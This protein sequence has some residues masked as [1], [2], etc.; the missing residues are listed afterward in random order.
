M[1]PVLCCA[2]G[3]QGEL[4][5]RVVL[6]GSQLDLSSLTPLSVAGCGGLQLLQWATK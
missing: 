5:V 4:P 6:T 3:V 2:R 1:L